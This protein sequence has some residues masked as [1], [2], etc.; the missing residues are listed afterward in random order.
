[1]AAGD[2]QRVWFPEM[3]AR[4]RCEWDSQMSFPALIELRDRLEAMLQ[5]IRSERH[6]VACLAL[7]EVRD[8]RTVG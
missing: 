4:L 5:Q 8:N 1:M 3:L 2:P 7:P 6:I